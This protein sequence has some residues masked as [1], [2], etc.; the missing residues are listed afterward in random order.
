MQ[1][2]FLNG[3]FSFLSRFRKKGVLTMK[4]NYTLNIAGTNFSIVSDDSEE[5][6]RSLENTVEQMVESAMRKGASSHKAALFVCMELC[7]M[8]RK[9]EPEKSENPKKSKKSFEEIVFPDKNQTTLF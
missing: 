7:D 5:Y 6:I 9:K 4:N 3:S 2:I 8:L 1:H